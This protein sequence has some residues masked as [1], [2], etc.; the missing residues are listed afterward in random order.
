M[1]HMP[2]LDFRDIR[3]AQNLRLIDVREQDEYDAGHVQ[4]AEHFALSL[5]RQG[6][7]PVADER[8]VAL[9][10]RSGARSAQAAQVLES[11]GFGEVINVSDGTL[12]AP[13]RRPR[14][15]RTPMNHDLLRFRA[16]LE[17]PPPTLGQLLVRA[18]P[19]A[20]ESNRQAALSQGL[21]RV[22][23]IVN[24][25]DG[26]LASPGELVELELHTATAPAPQGL[27]ASEL[28]R[29]ES[30]VL[31]DKPVG[32]LGTF[33]RRDPMHPLAFAADILGLDRQKITPVWPMPDHAG[34]PW[35]IAKTPEAASA[36]AA[37]LTG[38][39]MMV[40]WLAIVPRVPVPR[41][42]IVSRHGVPVTW[43][44]TQFKGGLCELQLIPTYGT[45]APAEL[46]APPELILEVLAKM[47]VP[48]LGDRVRGGYL[49]P[50]GLKLRLGAVLE[51]ASGLGHSWET[52]KGWWPSH[53]IVRAEQEEELA[54]L[55][56]QGSPQGFEAPVDQ[57]PQSRSKK[58]K[59]DKKL[60]LARPNVPTLKVSDKTLEI[61]AD[62]GHPWVL[63]DRRTGP[64]DHLR[65]GRIVAL[66]GS[67][68]R[69][70]PFALVESPTGELVARYWAPA[71][72]LR[73]AQNVPA[74]VELRVDR[75]IA[76]RTEQ[77]EGLAQ[78]DLFR[79]IHGQA[80]GLPGFLID[81]VGPLIRATLTSPAAA[82]LKRSVYAALLAHDPKATLIEVPHIEDVRARGDVLPTA[83]LVQTSSLLEPGGRVIGSEDGLRYW[84]EPWHGIDTGFFAD[85]RSN[86]RWLA[87]RARPGSRW[88]NLF[89]HTGAFSVMLAAQGAH[90]VNV[91]VSKR[92]LEW[93]A[94]N[95][96]LNDLDPGLCEAAAEDARAYVKAAIERG[97]RFDG[98]V[99][100]P[101]TAAQGK[102]GFWSIRKHFGSLLTQ[103]FG[104]LEPEGIML[105]CRNDRKR[106]GD[107]AQV[108]TDAAAQAGW[109]IG[110]LIGAPPAPDYP[111]L[112]GFPEGD[113]FE[114][115]FVRG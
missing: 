86:R 9:I 51:D 41:G 101:P 103:C 77:L 15:Y 18:W 109:D 79:L 66:E 3:D 104:L 111:S 47:D 34:G 32:M 35:L 82:A 65:P 56:P 81:R 38:G 14:G 45:S 27:E 21:V 83:E 67:G 70:G 17:F 75:A 25:R 23:G 106:R 24:T 30:W 36:L 96:A 63:A 40:T 33:D 88:L 1:K 114:G 98:I 78:T 110:E 52:P 90:S 26:A 49:A 8:D 50:G 108:V 43:S 87:Q 4:G 107:L 46:P 74:E 57:E 12:G 22:E 84:C 29:G 112:E 102:G 73:A 58:G 91:D 53:P 100:D 31:V 7:L 94:Q 61:M 68:G 64:R 5:I 71:W 37:S 93:T 11:H 39:H 72:D 69:G 92:Y 62:Q 105:V 42:Q 55:S 2:Y 28:A 85:Q 59:K 115:V 95:M 20:T 76:R 80:D 113:P 99:L 13:G 89:G 44:V 16:P 6:R 60:K 48:A 10:C 97:A 19:E 54:E